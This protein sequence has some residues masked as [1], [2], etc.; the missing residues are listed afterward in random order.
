MNV[1][2]KLSL[3]ESL[4]DHEPRRALDLL[5]DLYDEIYALPELDAGDA[6]E[7]SMHAYATADL[8][9]RIL[10]R[11]ATVLPEKHSYF[12]RLVHIVRDEIA[13]RSLGPG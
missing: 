5:L 3:A 6:I 2:E 7:L 10:E 13:R 12:D 9:A 1:R 4:L 11:R 8:L